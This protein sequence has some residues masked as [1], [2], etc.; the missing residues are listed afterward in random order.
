MSSETFSAHGPSIEILHKKI[1]ARFEILSGKIDARYVV[2]MVNKVSH[3]ENPF[4]ETIF[5]MRWFHKDHIS[6]VISFLYFVYK[7][8]P[9]HVSQLWFVYISTMSFAKDEIVYFHVCHN[10]Y[11]CWQTGWNVKRA[12]LKTYPIKYLVFNIQYCS[13]KFCAKEIIF[14]R[15]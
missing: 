14:S 4:A 3:L 12:Y 9:S 13:F 11:K 5:I 2:L 10:W 6:T 8:I 1:F 15:K 7:Y